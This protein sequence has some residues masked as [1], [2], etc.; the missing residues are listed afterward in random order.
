V[1][2][3]TDQQRAENFPSGR[4]VLTYMLN[5]TPKHW[6]AALAVTAG[7]LATS[8]PAGAILYTGHAG[9]G[10]SVYQHNQTDLEDAFQAPPGRLPG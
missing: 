7:L 4:D 6:I 2:F 1:T 3:V 9:L 10:A 8:A 5:F